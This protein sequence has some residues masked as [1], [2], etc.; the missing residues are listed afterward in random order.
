MTAPEIPLSCATSWLWK[1]QYVEL[2]Y[3]TNNGL[4]YARQH[5]STLDEDVMVQVQDKDGT[6][7]WVPAVTSREAR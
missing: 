6:A 4:D 7:A 1:G 3:F 5:S 2:W